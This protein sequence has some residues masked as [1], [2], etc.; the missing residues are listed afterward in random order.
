MGAQRDAAELK[1]HPFF[2]NIDWEALSLKQATPPFKPVVESDESTSNFDPEFTSADIREVGGIDMMD[3]D[4]DLDD[5]DPSEAWV[6]QSI[7]GTQ[8]QPNGPLG[9][10]PPK[11]TSPL[12]P[13]SPITNGASTGGGGGGGGRAQGIQ[14]KPSRVR[15]AAAAGSPLTNSVQENFIGFT[16]HGGESVAA[17]RKEYFQQRRAANGGGEEEAVADEDAPEVTTEDEFE[18]VGRSAGRY[19]NTRRHGGS[20]DEED[21]S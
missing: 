12:S 20:F 9:S 15:K 10:A 19:A 7:S 18:D 13:L 8:H 21:M 1:E 5:N 11:S 4:N 2:K 3:L 14:I 16:Y 6:S 17:P